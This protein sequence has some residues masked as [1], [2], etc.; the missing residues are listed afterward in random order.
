MG[1]HYVPQY[2]LKG[3]S[4]REGKQIWVYDKQERRKF[5]TQVKSI[6]KITGFYSPE[7]EQ[8]LADTIEVPANRVIRKIRDRDQITD[9]DKGILAEYMAVMMKRVPKG[10]KR[11]RELAPSVK[12]KLSQEI[13]EGLTILASIQPEKATLIQ[14]RE[15]EI[16]EILDKYSKEPP[17]D[18]WLDTIP[19][20][21]S[22]LV[23]AAL[24]G[25]I[26]RFLTFDAK[27]AFLTSD[28]PVF[29]FT[30][31]GISKPDSEVSFPI[32]SYVI[33]WATWQTDLPEGYITVTNQAVKEMNRRT[34]GNALRYVFHRKDEHWIL[35]FV[36]KGKWKLNLLR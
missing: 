4:N 11:L 32:S 19:P 16:Q 21:R 33:L 25:M 20:E 5:P 30:S 12:E 27:P 9:C 34:V 29:Y 17:K 36:T 31:I 18:I 14:R 2:Y 1:D 3:F 24:T 28:N 26:W 23:V 22:P 15:S 8:Y 10:K 13:H 6:A 35:P 7:V